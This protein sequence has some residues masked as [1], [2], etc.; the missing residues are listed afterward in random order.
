MISTLKKKKKYT[1]KTKKN[2][3]KN[4]LS[5]TKKKIK[6]ITLTVNNFLEDEMEYFAIFKSI[7]ELGTYSQNRVNKIIT[8]LDSNDSDINKI[9]NPVLKLDKNNKKN[10]FLQIYQIKNKYTLFKK[11]VHNFSKFNNNIRRYNESIIMM[12]NSNKIKKNRMRRFQTYLYL[13]SSIYENDKLLFKGHTLEQMLAN[14]KQPK[15]KMTAD[16][17]HKLYYSRLF[18]INPCYES[19]HLHHHSFR[20]SFGIT[21]PLFLIFQR[22]RELII[23]IQ[24]TW[25]YVDVLSNL[26]GKSILFSKIFEDKKVPASFKFLRNCHVHNQLAKN[27][28]KIYELILHILPTKRIRN[29]DKISICGHSMGGS[30]SSILGLLIYFNI[31]SKKIKLELKVITFN[32]ASSFNNDSATEKIREIIRKNNKSP[33]ELTFKINNIF[34]KQDS[35]CLFNIYSF[36]IFLS[37]LFSTKIKKTAE[38]YKY[39]LDKLKHSPHLKFINELMEPFY[40]NKD[41][42]GVIIDFYTFINPNEYIRGNLPFLF[43]FYT[44]EH[45]SNNFL[46]SP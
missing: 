13:V 29:I 1:K 38:N 44:D 17:F 9:Q 27:A 37:I 3:F 31:L 6:K 22:D 34:Y 41:E 5:L 45:S 10:I 32:T 35:A 11:I 15:I 20:S 23:T 30:I 4:I 14:H 25:R 24:G 33:K 46:N 2:F 12:I 26:N 28:F 16:N 8:L 43:S 18:L 21:T 42:N 7:F 39:Y 36:S 19:M 40:V